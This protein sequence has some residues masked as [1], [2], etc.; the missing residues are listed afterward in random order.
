MGASLGG[1]V[2]FFLGWEYPQVFGNVACLSSSFGYRDDLLRRVKED[3]L[4]DRRDLRIYLDSG[5][6]RDNYETTVTMANNGS[7]TDESR[8]SKP[9]SSDFP[10]VI[11]D[12]NFI[13]RF[14]P[15]FLLFI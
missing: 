10:D 4:D 2:S 8:P 12:A 14:S 13:M 15:K 9:L 7:N 11:G 6:P 5:W 1:V 3:C